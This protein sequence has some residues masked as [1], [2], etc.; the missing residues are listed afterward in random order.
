MP[1]LLAVGLMLSLVFAAG[2][3]STRGATQARTP[4]N[5]I[6]DGAIE[7]LVRR[8]VR[9]SDPGLKRAH[10]SVVSYNGIVLLLGQVDSES[11]KLRATESAGNIR[12]AR[13][14]HNEIEISGPISRVARSND[15]WLTSKVKS[16]L[17]ARRDI[18]GG[19]IK[20]VTENSVV[21]LMGLMTREHADNAVSVAQQVFGVQKIVK[22]FEYTD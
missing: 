1:Q 16:R 4:G 18:R 2:C 21:Y 14:I 5:F 11:L 15:T 10:L 17:V 12:K 8:E 9:K 13:K 6:D 19:R 3:A 7:T 22:V 20:V